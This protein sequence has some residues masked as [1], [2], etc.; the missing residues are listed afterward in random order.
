MPILRIKNLTRRRL[1]FDR[2]IGD[3][4]PEQTRDFE[5]TTNQIEALSASLVRFERA[6]LIEFNH[7]NI[8][9]PNDSAED[10]EFVTFADIQ[11]LINNAIGPAGQILQIQRPLVGAIDG[12]NTVFTSP[13]N[14]VRSAITQEAVY[15]NGQR[16]IEGPGNDYIATESVPA[17]GF[18]TVTFSFAPIPGDVLTIDL[19][20]F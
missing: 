18:D 8:V 2:V 11:T 3:I 10:T 9:S 1:V 6:G 16:L 12:V 19:Y 13:T 20:Q 4:L 14:W 17:A 7:I 15:Y 5:I